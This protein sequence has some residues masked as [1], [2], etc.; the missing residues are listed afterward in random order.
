MAGRSGRPPLAPAH[1]SRKPELRDVI[2]EVESRGDNDFVE[3]AKSFHALL[4]LEAVSHDALVKRVS[5]PRPPTLPVW[6]HGA[7]CSQVEELEGA[8]SSANDEMQHL[9]QRNERWAFLTSNY[10][11]YWPHYPPPSSV[12]PGCLRLRSV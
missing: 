7:C 2:R 4:R 5:C 9:R 8:L 6:D 1:E 3:L 12:N 10:H 11:A